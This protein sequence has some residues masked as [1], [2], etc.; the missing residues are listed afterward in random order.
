MEL[1]INPVIFK[2]G[3]FE[4]RW[5]SLAY[6]FG[7]IC[8]GLL[9]FYLNRFSSEVNIL[10]K[11]KTESLINYSVIGVILGGRLG[12]VLF[13]EPVY[14]FNNPSQIL[15]VWNGGMSFH[16][17]F[18]GFLFSVLLFCKIKKHSVWN[19]FDRAA[20]CVLPGLFFGRIANFINGEL[21]GKKTDIAFSFI[22]PASGDLAT[23]HPSQLYEAML[24][25][26]IP[27]II[28]IILL[29]TT[30]FFK[31]EG[32]F[33]G[34]FILLYGCARFFVEEFFREPDGVFNFGTIEVSTGQLLSIPMIILGL[35]LIKFKIRYQS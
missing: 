17:G 3:F 24:E 13:Y 2:L 7:F 28:F 26:F 29:K 19:I 27:F 15:A 34:L 10:S 30:N 11:T 35:I 25:G 16:G 22:F 31:R 33:S 18:L 12:Y 8:A 14:F 5:Y 9:A 1:F 20:V 21:W 6:I 23:R 32:L 4:L